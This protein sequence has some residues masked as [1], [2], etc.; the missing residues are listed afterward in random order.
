MLGRYLRG[1]LVLIVL[2][3]M[4]TFLVLEWVFHLP[5]ALWIGILTGVLEIIPLIGPITAGTIAAT[6]GFSQGGP[7]EAAG[8][9]YRVLHPAPGGGPAG[10]AAG[11]RAAPCTC[12]RW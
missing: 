4:V 2:M 1:Q 9:R 7:T 8:N 12:T 11:G 3:S 10:D 5:Y 6:V